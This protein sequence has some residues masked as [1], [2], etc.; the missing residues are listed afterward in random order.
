MD[1]DNTFASSRRTGPDRAD[2]TAPW[3]L[4]ATCEARPRRGGLLTRLRHRLSCIG[5][6]SRGAV[7]LEFALGLPIFLAMIYGVFEFGRIFWT[8]ST[9]EFAVEEAARFALVNPNASSTEITAIVTD[10]AAGLDV[11]RIAVNIFYEPDATGNIARAFVNVT[12]TYSYAPMIP[13]VLPATGGA[14]LDFRKFEMAIV[15]STRM[16]LVLPVN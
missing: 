7:A 10:K 2:S 14:T 5:D 16:A 11:A 4:G 13:L 15:S 6:D 3:R 9:M 1:T 12:G 8:Q